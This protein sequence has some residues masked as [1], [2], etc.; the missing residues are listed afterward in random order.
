MKVSRNLILKRWFRLIEL[1]VNLKFLNLINENC[2]LN[3]H[4]SS[5][6]IGTCNLQ[7]V[8]GS[9]KTGIKRSEW[10]VGKILKDMLKLLEDSRTW[11]EIYKNVAKCNTYPLPYCGHWWCENQNYC[12]KTAD[13][14]PQYM[15]FILHLNSFSKSK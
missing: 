3:E 14:F 15:K 5:I 13:I 8:H 2:D 9:L 11:G 10:K 7:A 1:S 4:S 6:N 12:E